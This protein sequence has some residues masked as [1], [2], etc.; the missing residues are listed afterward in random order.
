MR[1][2]FSLFASFAVALVFG[3][4]AGTDEDD[5]LRWLPDP[6]LTPGAFVES[7]AAAICV[8]GY[9][10]A[11]RPLFGLAAEPDLLKELHDAP[12]FARVI[13]EHAPPEVAGRFG[14]RIVS[15]EW[16]TAMTMTEP[17]AGSSLGLITAKADSKYHTLLHVAAGTRL[18]AETAA[19]KSTYTAS[20][21]AVDRNTPRA[22]RPMRI[23]Q[24]SAR[25]RESGKVLTLRFQ[26]LLGR[27][28]SKSVES[29][30]TGSRSG[31]S[32]DKLTT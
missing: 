29:R 21:A 5:R 9:D 1:L 25:V 14:P 24:Y 7:S 17:Q 11:H 13:N 27:S 12:S 18:R 31:P 23:A 3:A 20:V 15:G 28:E 26:A 30:L 6:K 4:T 10:R 16:A 32:S 19:L 22:S 2:L 8:H